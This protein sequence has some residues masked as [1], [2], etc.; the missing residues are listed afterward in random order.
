LIEEA[1]PI[2]RFSKWT[3][4]KEHN[5]DKYNLI[6]ELIERPANKDKINYTM[7][8]NNIVIL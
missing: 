4:S 5:E 8:N 6:K 2:L 1:T 7:K 3:I